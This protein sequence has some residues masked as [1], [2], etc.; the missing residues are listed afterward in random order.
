MHHWLRKGAEWS[1]N[2]CQCHQ[3]LLAT[4][5]L[6]QPTADKEWDDANE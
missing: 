3:H 6:L 5:C 2:Y 1:R 4:N